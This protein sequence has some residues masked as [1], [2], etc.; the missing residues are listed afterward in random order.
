M[1]ER[2]RRRSWGQRDKKTGMQQ[3]RT[4]LP[5][6]T[7]GR[8]DGAS[9]RIPCRRNRA[10]ASEAGRNPDAAAK[11]LLRK[12]YPVISD[13]HGR[14]RRRKAASLVPGILH[15][16]RTLA[17][18]GRSRALSAGDSLPALTMAGCVRRRSLR[19][20]SAGRR[21]LHIRSRLLPFRP[22]PAALSC[23]TR[24]TCDARF[25]GNFIYIIYSRVRA[26]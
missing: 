19:S 14:L 18:T 3:L 1:P 12:N 7:A 13:G 25:A 8:D 20:A 16:E 2:A 15:S 5:R 4:G 11:H 26:N 9:L 22:A 21:K 17:E 24:M 10:D 23:R 6:R